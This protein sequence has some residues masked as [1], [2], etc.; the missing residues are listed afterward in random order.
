MKC[1]VS[2]ATG[3]QTEF[4]QGMGATQT[5]VRAIS[6]LKADEQSAAQPKGRCVSQ[7]RDRSSQPQRDG[8]FQL[9]YIFNTKAIGDSFG[10]EATVKETRLLNSHWLLPAT[11]LVGNTSALQQAPRRP[12]FALSRPLPLPRPAITQRVPSA[13]AV[14]ANR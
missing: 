14:Q 4:Y 9:L 1:I 5:K 10:E 6:R 3:R 12:V 8:S 2:R 11:A 7:G 13:H